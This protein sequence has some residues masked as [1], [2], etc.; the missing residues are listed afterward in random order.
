[1]S[2]IPSEVE[3]LPRRWSFG[4]EHEAT[5]S[6]DC[7]ISGFQGRALSPSTFVQGRSQG[8]MTTYGVWKNELRIRNFCGHYPNI[9]LNTRP[10]MRSLPSHNKEKYLIILRH[11]SK[12]A[13]D[14]RSQQDGT[15]QLFGKRG[16]EPPLLWV[17]QHQGG[18]A[19]RPIRG[20][21][22][23]SGSQLE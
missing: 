2:I 19:G 7:I 12:T 3:H 22:T 23:T 13:K 16:A 1:M 4:R 8:E 14:I 5:P 17:V 11:S 6:S 9:R 20:A 21:Q 15:L 10:G 18:T